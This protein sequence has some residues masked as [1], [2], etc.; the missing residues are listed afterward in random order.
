MIKISKKGA[1]SILGILLLAV[2]LILVLSY[3]NI[4]LRAIV[5]SPSAQNNFGYVGSSSRSLWNDYLAKPVHDV[6][7]SSIVKNLW[8][9]FI[10]N[11]QRIHEG[12]PTDF[13][14]FAPSVPFN[15]N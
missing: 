13:Q 12:K 4:S 8:N 10:D 2:V 9:S 5:E 6:L 7:N 1:I 15:S 14:K 11:M 3:F